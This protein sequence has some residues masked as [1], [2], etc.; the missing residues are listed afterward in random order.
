MTAALEGARV[1]GITAPD[2]HFTDVHVNGTVKSGRLEIEELTADGQEIG[3][4]GE[5]NVLLREPLASS[6]LALDLTVTPA[7]AASDGLKMMI[8]MLPGSSGEGGARRIA[9]SGTLGRPSTPH[10]PSACACGW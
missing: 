2:L 9:V 6:V 8:N 10:S 1:R 3:L 5:G 4:R 7:A